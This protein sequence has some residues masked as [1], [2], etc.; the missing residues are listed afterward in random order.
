MEQVKK[1]GNGTKFSLRGLSPEK[2][3][4]AE[5]GAHKKKITPAKVGRFLFSIVRGVIVFGIGYVILYPI[6][7]RLTISFMDEKDLYDATVKYVPK[8]FT[9]WNYRRDI[10]GTE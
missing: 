5:G 7:V 9:L 2:K 6:F 3:A 4:S 10:D 1:L 8:T